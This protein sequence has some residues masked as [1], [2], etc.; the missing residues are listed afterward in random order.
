MKLKTL[1]ALIALGLAA[2]TTHAVVTDQQVV[3]PDPGA[4]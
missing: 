2:A 4:P 3:R 1:P